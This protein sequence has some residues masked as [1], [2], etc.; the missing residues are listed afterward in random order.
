MKL[1][2]IDRKKYGKRE[3]MPKKNEKENDIKQPIIITT[4]IITGIELVM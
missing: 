4:Q 1:K 2:A 3:R